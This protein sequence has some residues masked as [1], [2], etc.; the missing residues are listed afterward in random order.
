MTEILLTIT[1]LS[2]LV[3]LVSSMSG[4]GLGLSLQQ[5]VAPLRNTRLVLF[6][7]VANFVIA[8]ALAVGIGRL[9]RLDEPFALGLVLLGLAAGAPFMPKIAA[10]AKGDLALAVGLMVLLMVGTTVLLPVALPRLVEGAQVNPWK[11]A[12]FL[13]LLLLLPLVA[14]LIVKARLDPVAMRLRPILERVSTISLLTMLVLIM[15][16]NFKGVLRIFGTGAILAAILFAGLSALAGR[17]LG[18]RDAAQRTVLGLGTGLRNIP[19]ALIVS[20]QNF[21]DPNVSVMVIVTTLTGILIL[22]PTARL[23]GKRAPT[24]LPGSN[25]PANN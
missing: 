10:V 4:I 16:I 11:I 24:V 9:L 22:G 13:T 15:A 21:K 5:V 1:R 20:T 12:R 8:P 2:V 3:F 6:A 18:G 17:L 23:M 25:A 7:L 14:G 19:A